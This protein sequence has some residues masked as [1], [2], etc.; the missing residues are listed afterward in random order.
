MLVEIVLMQFF[1]RF[2]GVPVY[3]VIITLGGLLFFSGLGSIVSSGWSRYG[4][5][6]AVFMIPAV[7]YLYHKW[8]DTIFA[9]FA[10]FSFEA[11]LYL[12][13]IMMI[14]ISFLMGV[15]FP[16][17]MEKIKRDI[18]REY[19][20]LMYAISGGAGAVAAVS[21]IY[22]NISYGFLFTF[23][24]GM[25]AYAAGALLLVLILKGEK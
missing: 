19:A 9:F 10:P 17:A 25:A 24:L 21:A 23:S 22:F 11:R 8:L 20:T 18:S 5:H 3:S 16:R 7:L 4:I 13:V 2:I 14:P 15:P 12:A 1:Q 6:I